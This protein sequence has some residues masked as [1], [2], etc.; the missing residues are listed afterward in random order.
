MLWTTA[1]MEESMYPYPFFSYGHTCK[2][3]S[4]YLI[5]TCRSTG[6][7][8]SISVFLSRIEKFPVFRCFRLILVFIRVRITRLLRYRSKQIYQRPLAAAII[9]NNKHRGLVRQ[10]ATPA[11]GKR[12]LGSW[13]YWFMASMSVKV[14]SYKHSCR[15]NN[16]CTHVPDECIMRTNSCKIF[17]LL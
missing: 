15:N 5:V 16:Q 9:A 4:L 2:A 14:F 8:S 13:M 17:A 1:V 3:Q 6:V 12:P 10:Y 7:V 11:Q